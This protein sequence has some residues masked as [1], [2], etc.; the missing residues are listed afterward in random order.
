M[1]IDIHTHIAYNK[2]YPEAFLKGMFVDIE[3]SFA[4]PFRLFQTRSRKK[5][6]FHLLQCFLK[7]EKGDIQVRQMEQAS[8]N[9]AILLIIDAGIAL[10]EAEFSIEEIFEHYYQVLKRHPE[11]FIVFGNV[12]PRRGDKGFDLFSKGIEELGFK[13]L[14][15]YPPMGYAMDDVRLDKYYE[16]C[17]EKRLPVLIHTGPSLASLKNELAKPE[18]IFEIAQR[19]P[20]V[21]FILAHAGF[22]LKRAPL[23]SMC[24][25]PNVYFDIAGFYSVYTK[26]DKRTIEE[27]SMIFGPEYNSRILF[28]TD[29]PLFNLMNPLKN[30]MTFLTELAHAVNASTE[31]LDNILYKNALKVLNI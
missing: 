27:L 30:Q 29:W 25:L 1:A 9:K 24:E 23:R 20:K 10:G 6:I 16:L 15:L 12:D 28:G 8:I 17:S 3:R 19:Y 31:A 5:K 26:V 21:N 11:K 2:L 14:K 7:D 22:N 4:G 18:C 13:G